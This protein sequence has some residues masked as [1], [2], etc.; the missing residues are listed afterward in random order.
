MRKRYIAALVV[1]SSAGF[2]MALETVGPDRLMDGLN[3][4]VHCDRHICGI[5]HEYAV[6]LLSLVVF[7]MA[8]Q[9]IDVRELRSRRCS[10]GFCSESRVAVAADV[11]VAENIDAVAVDR[12][13]QLALYRRT[14]DTVGRLALPLIMNGTVHLVCL[15]CMT[16]L[17][18]LRSGPYL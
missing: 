6:Y 8:N 1:V 7:L 5:G 13:V 4:L 10:L 15:L 14:A 11:P 17:A 9:A 3:R 2:R 12:R 18:L 16:L